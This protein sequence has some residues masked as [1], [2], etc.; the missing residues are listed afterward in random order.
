SCYDAPASTTFYSLSLHD[1]LPIFIG[2]NLRTFTLSRM[3]FFAATA[4]GVVVLDA[5]EAIHVTGHQHQ[6]DQI[7][8]DLGHQLRHAFDDLTRSEEHTSEPSHVKISYAVF[9]LKK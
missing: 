7:A 1:A 3:F 8:L 2:M 4:L 5:G 6:L 9:C